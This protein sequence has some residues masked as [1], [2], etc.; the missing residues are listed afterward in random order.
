MKPELVF[1]AGNRAISPAQT[2]VVAGLPS[3]SLLSTG[4]NI[5]AS[6]FEP[7][8]ATSAA[9]AQGA[10]LSAQISAAHPDYW[11]E[12]VRA[13][14]IHS[15]GWTTSM[16]TY[17]DEEN[18]TKRAELVRRFGYG[19]P[20]LERALASVQNYLALIAQKSIQP[21]RKEQ[22]NIKF[23]EAH[24]FPLPWPIE[25][26]QDL[27][28]QLVR[29][30]VTLSYFVEPN[31]R[32][33]T[34]IDTARYQSFGLRFDLKRPKENFQNFLKRKNLQERIAGE[35]APKTSE[36]NGWLLGEQQITVGSLHCNVWQGTA[37]E[38]AGRNALWIYPVSGWWRERKSLKRFNSSARYSLV[39]TLETENQEIDLY[40]PTET[41]IAQMIGIQV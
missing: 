2:D 36:N 35:S 1:E 16:K 21:F 41:Q 10:R 23:N 19:V 8:W 15:A 26:L 4:A 31:P 6:P 38:L 18:K 9:A 40:T 29:L 17:L 27:D 12:T 37:A 14:M 11:P 33:S 3:L 7:F 34:A 28:E 25:T 13:L 24:L 32:F 20:S 30:K 22:S 39:L 5:A